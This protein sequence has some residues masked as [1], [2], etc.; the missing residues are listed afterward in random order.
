MARID[1]YE[2]HVGGSRGDLNAAWAPADVNQVR[3]VCLN[4]SGRIIKGIAGTSG[5]VGVLVLNQEMPAGRRVDVMRQGEVLEC[6]GLIAGTVYYA[7]ADGTIATGLT[8][9]KVGHT[10][11][12]DRLVVCLQDLG[13]APAAAV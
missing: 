9:Y 6:T 4:A 1:L 8:R 5:C 13:A 7:Q 10:I 12:A 2:P 11:E 3:A